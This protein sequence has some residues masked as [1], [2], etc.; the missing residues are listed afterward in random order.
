MNRRSH[1]RAHVVLLDKPG[2]GQM[3]V[4]VEAFF[5]FSFWIAEQLEDLVASWQRKS[6]PAAKRITRRRLVTARR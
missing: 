5:E 6:S 2:L 4:S 1:V 3:Q